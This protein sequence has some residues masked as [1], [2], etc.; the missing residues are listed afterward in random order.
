MV[1]T[2]GFPVTIFPT[3][4]I[5]WIIPSYDHSPID[6][7]ERPRSGRSEARCIWQPG[8]SPFGIHG[9]EMEKTV[10]TIRLE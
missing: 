8:E 9:E 2:H 6:F 4:P 10:V 1:K 7:A 3:K 5:H